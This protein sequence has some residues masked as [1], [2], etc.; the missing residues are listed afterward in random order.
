MTSPDADRSSLNAALALAVTLPG[1]TLLYLLL[2]IY[3]ASFGV[4]LA[5]AG[6]LLAANRLVRIIG[7]QWVARFY[8][9][10]GPRVACVAA[11]V[12]AALATLSYATLSGV[13]FLLAGRLLWGISYAA[14]NIANQAL[15]TAVADGAAKRAGRSRAL[16]ATG[17]TL[18]LVGGA[19]LAHFMGP[20]SVFF[21]L[22]LIACVAPF[23][24]A[25]L[26]SHPE[27]VRGAGPR[28]AR[29]DALSVWSFAQ[30]F[31]LDGI[32]VF[33]LGLLAMQ[34][35]PSGAVLAAGMALALR[36]AV[37]MAFS[38][39]G[40]RMAQR[41]GAMHV[42]VIASVGAAGGLVL[43]ALDG[44]LLWCGVVITITL[45]ALALPLTAPLVA[46]AHPG[47]ARVPALAR[48][49]T[50]RDIGAGTGPI[51][52]GILFPLVAPLALYGPTACLVVVT[53]LMLLTLRT[54]AEPGGR[55]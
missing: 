8:A 28:F 3:A 30:G 49:A 17:P 25:R 15:P 23:L 44:W 22:T 36:F 48:Q 55:D 6:L 7:Y 52:A 20:R 29:P 51:V 54:R 41:F 9:A 10:R 35:H 45:R 39:V 21:V 27:Q 40:G 2:P 4:S 50:W 42:L 14:L 38:P 18:G 1:D 37:E 16:I 32:F 13:W 47:P 11:S 53:S 24:A 43:V 31:T 26:P 12:G 34:N 46:E 33:G 19:V 5:E